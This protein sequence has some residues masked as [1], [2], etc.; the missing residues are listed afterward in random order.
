M[1]LAELAKLMSEDAGL[2]I[3]PICATPFKPRHSRQKTC[4]KDECKKIYHSQYVSEYSK[5]RRAENPEP[6]RAYNRKMMRRYR[7]KEKAAERLDEAEA[8]WRNRDS[9]NDSIVAEDYGV[10]QAEK[11]L[12]QIPKID[13]SLGKEK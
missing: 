8:Y 7:A 11:T 1:Q 12:A 13:V 3:C 9:I 10:R 6:L 4:G 5:R 2:H